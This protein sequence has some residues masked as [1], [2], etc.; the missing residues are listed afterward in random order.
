MSTV[1]RYTLPY[2][3]YQSLFYTT[4]PTRRTQIQYIKS[5]ESISKNSFIHTLFSSLVIATRLYS[6][7]MFEY[8]NASIANTTQRRLP[9]ES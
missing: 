5:P 6:Y 4:T 2:Y 1:L 8:G 7:A 3:D 9:D